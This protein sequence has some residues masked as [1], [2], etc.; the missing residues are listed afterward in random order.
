M[1]YPNI[2]ESF[3]YNT[4]SF[5]ECLYAHCVGGLPIS[6]RET[7]PIVQFVLRRRVS[8]HPFLPRL[9]SWSARPPLI[10]SVYRTVLI[11]YL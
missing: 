6:I 7:A 1:L 3:I 2:Y 9:D 4:S 8:R 10:L 5:P 11:R